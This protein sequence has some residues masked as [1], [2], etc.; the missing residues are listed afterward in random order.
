MAEA[1]GTTNSS[2]VVDLLPNDA[3]PFTP[4]YAIYEEHA[5]ARIALINFMDGQTAGYNV[6]LSIGGNQVGEP[7]DTPAQ[8]KVKYV[9]SVG[10]DGA[11]PNVVAGIC[12]PRLSAR[13]SRLRGQTRCVPM[14]SPVFIVELSILSDVRWSLPSGR[15][16]VRTGVRS[17]HYVRSGSEHLSD[18]GA[19]SRRGTRLPL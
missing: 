19:S 15:P 5:L 17:D 9:V 14:A 12:L 11:V 3:N 13:K 2:R 4:A 1:L 18:S 7:N 8:V 10:H 16:S 6:T